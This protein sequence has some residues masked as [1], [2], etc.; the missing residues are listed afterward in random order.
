[1]RPARLVVDTN[2]LVS[3]MLWRGVPGQLLALADEHG[4]RLY[5]SRVLLDE[6]HD[7]LHRPR[8]AKPV[9]ATGHSADQMVAHYRRIAT[10]VNAHRLAA[11]VSRDTD[12]DAVL[13]CAVAAQADLVVTGDDDLLVLR[14]YADIEIITAAAAIARIRNARQSA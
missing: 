1:M 9:A 6:L 13:A 8:L 10:L 14:R 12:D 4:I 7:V 3:A 5:T 11:P 2:V